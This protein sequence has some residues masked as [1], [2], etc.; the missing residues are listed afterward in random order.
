MGAVKTTLE[1]PDFLFRRAKSFAA[2]RG[3]PL[4][5]LVTE[6]LQD[7]LN[8][9]GSSRSRPWMKHMG[10]LKHLRKET[11]RISKRIEEAFEQVDR[12]AWE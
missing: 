7:K 4:R 11:E 6:A 5:Q 3:I 9:T 1:M 8:L 2:E 12:E 10:R